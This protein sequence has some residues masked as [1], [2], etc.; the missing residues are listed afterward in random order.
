MA[1]WTALQVAQV[2]YQ[3]G[4][5][6]DKLA[7]AV[8]I[9]WAESGL[10]TDALGVNPG[11]RPGTVASYDRGLWQINSAAHPDVTEACAYDPV[12]NAAAM[13]RISNQGQNWSPWVTY[14]TGAY[15]QYLAAATLAAN[16][17]IGQV[18]QALAPDPKSRADAAAADIRNGANPWRV[19]TALYQAIVDDV[20]R[21]RFAGSD[22]GAV[23]GKW[24][25]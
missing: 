24:L 5:P 3:V 20:M 10:R 16:M 2:A 21:D 1:Q 11:P 12:C 9:A 8:A 13:I 17:A 7:V 18:N 19:F 6:A 4:L 23:L 25:G 14:N 15:Q 22:A